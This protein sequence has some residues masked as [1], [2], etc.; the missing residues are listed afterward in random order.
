[1]RVCLFQNKICAEARDE[2][3]GE[4]RPQPNILYEL[5]DLTLHAHELTERLSPEH[6]NTTKTSDKLTNNYCTQY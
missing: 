2:G 5:L 3:E 4:V 1:M 6:K